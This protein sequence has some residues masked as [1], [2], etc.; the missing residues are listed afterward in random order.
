MFLFLAQSRLA[1]R[2]T[3]QFLN[4]VSESHGLTYTE[5]YIQKVA[6]KFLVFYATQHV[7]P[8]MAS[9]DQNKRIINN[10]GTATFHEFRIRMFALIQYKQTW[11]ERSAIG[12]IPMNSQICHNCF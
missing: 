5:T 1:S 2:H 11:P 3:I 6:I 10:V 9:T 12:H 8:H 4:N 7:M